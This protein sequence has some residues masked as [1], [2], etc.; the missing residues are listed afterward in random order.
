MRCFLRAE[1]EGLTIGSIQIDVLE[2][3]H[4]SVILGINDPNASPNYRVE[5][6]YI[7]S[8]DDADATFEPYQVH[9]VSSFALP[10]Q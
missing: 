10:V 4:G 9:E 8:D 7:Q 1:N 3:R 5:V 6:L 2:V